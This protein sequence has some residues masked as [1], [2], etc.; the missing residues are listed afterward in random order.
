MET[1]E[2]ILEKMNYRI[3]MITTSLFL[4]CIPAV[5]MAQH[6]FKA[7]AKAS[8]LVW[9]G[10]KVMGEHSGKISVKNGTV[11]LSPQGDIVKADFVIDM[12]SI[13]CTDITDAGTNAQLVGHLKSDDFFG[14]AKFPEA[15]FVISKPVKVVNGVANV[16][17]DLTI[18]GITHPIQ[19]KAIVNE[20]EG[21]LSIRGNAVVDRSKYN[22]QYGS[23]SFFASLGDNMIYDEFFLT[24]NVLAVK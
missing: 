2:N 11:V 10:K 16:S 17:G 3:M 5:M 1:R 20:K 7:D 15:K 19:F 22:I 14:S 9:I 23:G 13:T 21:K 6:T 4:F 8:Q 18:K 24:L 12:N